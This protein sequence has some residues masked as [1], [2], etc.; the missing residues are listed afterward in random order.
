[1]A[2]LIALNGKQ[3]YIERERKRESE[4]KR[5]RERETAIMI[6]RQK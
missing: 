5:G 2:P 1:M 6:E 4:R 3:R